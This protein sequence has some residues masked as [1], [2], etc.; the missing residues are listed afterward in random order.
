MSNSRLTKYGEWL[1]RSTMNRVP[2][3]AFNC[4]VC[5][6]TLMTPYPAKESD[7]WDSVCTCPGCGNL[8]MKV[9]TLMPTG[10]TGT[11]PIVETTVV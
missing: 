5:D 9:I 2:L 11:T 7:V 1:A 8:Y 3:T 6:V 10:D 4:P